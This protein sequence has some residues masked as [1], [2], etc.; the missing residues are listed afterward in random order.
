MNILEKIQNQ[1]SN[2]SSNGIKILD[3]ILDDPA[4]ISSYSSQAL[5][6]KVG[7]SQ[8]SIVK[9]TQR[10]GFKGF[11]AFK[12]AIIEDLGRKQ[13]ILEPERPIHNKINSDD[14]SLTI[15]QKLVQE[16][17]HALIATTNAINFSEFE[18][19]TTLLNQAQ[20]IQI[21][22]IGG[23]ALT[24]KDLAFKLLKIGMTA[25]TE[26]DS[27]VQIATANT[28][29]KQDVQ[30][31]ISYSGSRKEILMAA[32]TAMDKG[33]TVIALT[34]TKKSPLRKLANFCID[35]IADE[36]Q[37]RS[38]SISS[39]TAQNVITDLLFMTLLQIKSDKAKLL[40]DEISS[41]MNRI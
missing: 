7:V 1:R 8:S 19:V 2:L 28:L 34:S 10:L 17:T 13:A 33:A 14:S 32:Q 27:H 39:R 35:T 6:A 11:T 9:L 16:K 38:S 21:V 23:S 4:S 15:A 22:G 26:Q 25:L 3:F 24:A 41:T 30:I 31:V 12:L 29:T 36:R 20:R 5:A 37:F 40:I 18:L